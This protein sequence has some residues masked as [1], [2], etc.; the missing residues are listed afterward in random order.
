LEIA[1]GNGAQRG[2]EIGRVL[3]EIETVGILVAALKLSEPSIMFHGWEPDNVTMVSSFQPRRNWPYP[4]AR[5][6]RSWP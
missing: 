6:S 3:E 4:S 1:I 2:L 5:E